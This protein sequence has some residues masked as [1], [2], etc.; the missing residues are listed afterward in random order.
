MTEILA[1]SQS[2]ISVI[3]N[4]V[5][6]YV[7]DMSEQMQ[8]RCPEN[9]LFG[10][11]DDLPLY[12]S[13]PKWHPFV[14]RVDEELAGFALID[15]HRDAAEVDFNMGEFFIL[16]KLR[17]RGIGRLVAKQLFDRFVGIWQVMQ[18]PQTRQQFSSGQM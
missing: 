9:G 7:Y 15:D 3:Q 10:G 2:D 18:Y 5:R 14:I 16:R 1:A 6:F 11:C 13:N 12:F 8:W 4:L 17:R